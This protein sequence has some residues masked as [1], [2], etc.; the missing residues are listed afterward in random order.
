MIARKEI[1]T[2]MKEKQELMDE[3]ISR[4]QLSNQYNAELELSKKGI[5]FISHAINF[6]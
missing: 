1:V 4:T 5:S 3:M 6:S 2:L